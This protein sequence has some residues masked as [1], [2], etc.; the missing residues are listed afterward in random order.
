M[1][2]I[3]LAL[4]M[5]GYG[6]WATHRYLLHGL[7]R[8]RKSY[9]AF[10][11][12]EHHQS[13]RRHGGYDPD[14]EG[15]PWSTLT[16]A[17]EALGLLA[18]GI[19]H[20]PLLPVAPYYTLTTWYCLDRYRRLHRRAHLDPAWGRVH[21]PW[22]YDHHMGDQDQ[23]W[24]VT[25]GWFDALVGTRVAYLGT[26]KELAERARNASRASDAAAGVPAR[27]RDRKG[28]REVVSMM[29]D[30]VRKRRRY[31]ANDRA[32]HVSSPVSATP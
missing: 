14:Y 8:S 32:G 5:F 29:L 11:F 30:E 19:A 17:G 31:G 6:E 3:P 21:L 16:Q 25:W 22:H 13:V 27:R 4:A 15:P 1:I 7:G 9:F 18:V 10:H 2:G 23:N 28:V 20:L 12:H 24:G 26:E